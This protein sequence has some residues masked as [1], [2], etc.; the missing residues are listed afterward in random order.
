MRGTPQPIL[1]HAPGDIAA[2]GS[3]I[4]EDTIQRDLLGGVP[5]W[6]VKPGDDPGP[7]SA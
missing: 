5:R 7:V 2:H 6:L 4:D 3:S 1:R